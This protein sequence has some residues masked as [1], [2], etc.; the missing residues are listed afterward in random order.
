MLGGMPK[1]LIVLCHESIYSKE[2]NSPSTV[3]SRNNSRRSTDRILERM[4]PRGDPNYRLGSNAAQHIQGRWQLH[5]P[6]GR[7]WVL[8]AYQSRSQKPLSPNGLHE[9]SEVL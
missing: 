5:E 7:E 8:F 1:S 4:R 2:R 9:T 6:E 3:H